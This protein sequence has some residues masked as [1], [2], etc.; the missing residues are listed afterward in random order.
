MNMNNYLGDYSRGKSIYSFDDATIIQSY[1]NAP[2]YQQ[3]KN[4][5]V[6]WGKRKSIDGKEIPIRYH[7][8]I[9]KKPEIGNEYKVFFFLDPDDHITKAKKPFIFDTVEDFPTK[10]EVEQYYY[11]EDNNIIYRWLP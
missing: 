2:Q 5:F 4:D 7:L 1:S 10:G 3:I 8:A 11:A 6:I 9:D